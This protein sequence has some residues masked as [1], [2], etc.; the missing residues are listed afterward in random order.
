MS[1]KIFLSVFM[2]FHKEQGFVQFIEHPG[3]LNG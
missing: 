3:Q 1:Y 2:T